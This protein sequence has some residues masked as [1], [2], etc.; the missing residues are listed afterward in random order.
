MATTAIQQAII[1]AAHEKSG[2]KRKERK[3]DYYKHW[4]PNN[5]I[6]KAV[7]AMRGSNYGPNHSNYIKER[8]KIRNASQTKGRPP[9]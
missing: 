8:Q 5:S 7:Q 1:D 4:D 2:K 6:T 3:S 9:G